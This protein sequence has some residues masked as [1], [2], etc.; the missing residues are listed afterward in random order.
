MNKWGCVNLERD[1]MYGEV[2]VRLVQGELEGGSN[3]DLCRQVLE[4]YGAFS[5]RALYRSDV[6][7]RPI[8]CMW[9]AEGGQ[10][11]ILSSISR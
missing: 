4:D 8:F 1:D 6:A 10:E 9:F 11:K 7:R 2:S 5:R 3:V